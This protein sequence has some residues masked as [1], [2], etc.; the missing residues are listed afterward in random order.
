MDGTD[1]G[2]AADPRRLSSRPHYHDDADGHHVGVADGGDDR[3][4]PP[5]S[6]FD[7]DRRRAP[8]ITTTTTTTTTRPAATSTP[9][10][11]LIGAFPSDPLPFDDNDD[12]TSSSAWPTPSQSSSSYSSTSRVPLSPPTIAQ[13]NAPAPQ[14]TPRRL[15]SRS[16]MRSLRL[17]INSSKNNPNSSY[18]GDAEDGSDDG[19]PPPA[20]A[21]SLVSPLSGSA[22]RD[23]WDAETRR[24]SKRRSYNKLDAFLGALAAGGGG[25]AAS[26]KSEV[27]AD[28]LK[29]AVQNIVQTQAELARMVGELKQVASV[30]RQN[31]IAGSVG[32][33]SDSEADRPP[34]SARFDQ[35]RVGTPTPMTRARSNTS[36]LSGD[37]SAPGGG[38]VFVDPD[39]P[40]ITSPASALPS[41]PSTPVFRANSLPLP[42]PL[43]S[44]HNEELYDPD[45][46]RISRM[47]D[48]LLVEAKE[49][50]DTPSAVS[51]VR[52]LVE[53]SE[54]DDDDLRRARGR[55][56]ATPVDADAT[57]FPPTVRR[58]ASPLA[59]HQRVVRM[60][61]LRGTLGRKRGAATPP[62]SAA[63]RMA[64]M[65]VRWGQRSF[66]ASRRSVAWDTADR[67]DADAADDD[68]FDGAERDGVVDDVDDED[69]DDDDD[70]FTD[71]PADLPASASAGL[72]SSARRRRA[73]AFDGGSGGGL[74]TA[75]SADDGRV[76]VVAKA[77]AASR[78]APPSLGVAE[79]A[80][81]LVQVQVSLVV[82]V[83]TTAWSFMGSTASALWGGGG[84]TSTSTAAGSRSPASARKGKMRERQASLSPAATSAG[85]P[86]LSRTAVGS[87]GSGSLGRNGDR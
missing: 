23:A 4:A 86:G 28:E 11:H 51:R 2:G 70:E 44:D 19:V 1:S 63:S 64:A 26:R 49:A 62:G 75:A 47:L 16:S 48:T 68:G 13:D 45:F 34:I 29:S 74:V 52:R 50:I 38:R 18:D 72:S 33:P 14:R 8:R 20:Y 43:L 67:T 37:A 6:F 5:P 83:V 7:R 61:P 66:T 32:Y 46:Q 80:R 79:T 22:D 53:S 73:S 71:A 39:D 40:V 81:V 24:A 57:E 78:L 65:R 25:R 82:L 10:P 36:S 9:P 56:A 59:P 60:S 3:H 54:D 41:R 84:A 69:E 12:P 76:A 30:I 85:S 15:Q 27:Q 21:P 31:S 58:S 87:H 35:P 17:A 55:A 42:P 77:A